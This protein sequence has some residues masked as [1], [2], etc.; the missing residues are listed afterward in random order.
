MSS[1]WSSEFWSLVDCGAWKIATQAGAAHYSNTCTCGAFIDSYPAHVT[2]AT[3]GNVH[4]TLDQ[5]DI[6]TVSLREFVD[7]NPELFADLDTLPESTRS[8]GCDRC[9]DKTI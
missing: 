7:M 5:G 9:H 8:Q 3:W 4:M 1:I 2:H 6:V